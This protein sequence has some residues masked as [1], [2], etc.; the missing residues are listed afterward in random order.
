[1]NLEA[2]AKRIRD[3]REQ[4]KA[5]TDEAAELAKSLNLEVGNHP[6]GRYMVQVQEVK[7]FDPATAEKVLS[8]ELFQS[9]LVPKPDTTLAK[10]ML[11]G[12]EFESCQKMSGTKV[13]IRDITDEDN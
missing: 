13:V 9:I 10:K 12:Y 6:A 5:L 8:P 7:R 1:M 11:T 4:A 3:L 2:T